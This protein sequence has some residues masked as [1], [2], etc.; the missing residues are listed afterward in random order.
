L[1]QKSNR[2]KISIQ[3]VKFDTFLSFTKA[4]QNDEEDEKDE[5]D[6]QQT[7]KNKKS[8]IENKKISNERVSK[9]E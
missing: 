9:F 1:E 6:E 2:I 4:L 5:D 3:L 7:N 8:I